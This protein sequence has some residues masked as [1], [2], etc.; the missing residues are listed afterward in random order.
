[1]SALLARLDAYEKL[2]R[3]DK[4]IGALLLLWP[5]LWALWLAAEG[6][7]PM[8]TLWVFVLGTLLMRSAGCA[9]ND[10]ADRRFDAEVE[11]TR[12]RPLARGTIRPW[13]AL[14]VAAVLS[15][16]AF[17][18]VL[19]LNRL[20][21]ALS[22]AALAI[23][24]VY[25]FTKRFFS[26]PQAFLGIAFSA[27]IPMAFAAVRGDVP[28]LAWALVA[29]NFFWTIAYD[30]E[31]AMVDREDDRRIGIRTSALLF[32]K[33]DV[34]AIMA[35]YV[36]FLGALLGIGY[37]QQLGAACFLGIAVAAVLV[38]Y[39][40]LLIRGRTREGCFKAFRHNNWVGLAVFAGIAL[41]RVPWQAWLR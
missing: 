9:V 32:G 2:I 8:G 21:I 4:P 39:H 12:D 5:T 17:A 25:P 28:L 22:V 10:F 38:G 33:Y 36:A 18:L 1:M 3:L 37:W 31:Y 14:A 11:R 13:E 6:V 34:A 19:H 23:A 16:A 24:V 26:M 15:L 40:Y 27:G 35:C 20:T 30:T 41:D 7:P 29:A